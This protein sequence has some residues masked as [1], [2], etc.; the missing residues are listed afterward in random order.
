MNSPNI[1]LLTAV[2]VRERLGGVSHV[3]LWRWVRAGKFPKPIKPG[4]NKLVR[5]LAREVDEH[6]EARVT[7]RD[8][9][10]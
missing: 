2:Q 5:W 4:D 1:E 10:G 9:V 3:T 6:I 7:E 8:A